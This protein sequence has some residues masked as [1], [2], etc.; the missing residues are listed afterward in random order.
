MTHPSRTQGTAD[1]IVA[2][3]RLTNGFEVR[4]HIPEGIHIQENSYVLLRGVHLR[5]LPGVRYQ[6]VGNEEAPKVAPPVHRTYFS[7]VTKTTTVQKTEKTFRNKARQKNQEDALSRKLIQEVADSGPDVN[8]L[9]EK[10]KLKRE[11]LGR[12]T[13]F[14]LRAL[15]EWSAGKLPSQPAMR[16]LHEVRRLLDELAKIVKAERIPEWLHR[17]NP[18][19]APLTPLQVIELG[20]IDRLWA[21]VHDLGSGQPS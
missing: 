10:Y 14:S 17:P 21:M 19:F 5:D 18:T 11:E 1:R 8:T 4:A 9:C 15:A 16:R 2:K 20:E 3:V 12:L 7:T 6:I 13:G